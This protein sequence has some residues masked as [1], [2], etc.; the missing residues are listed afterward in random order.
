MGRGG[1]DIIKDRREMCP[2]Q[3]ECIIA[4]M[5][6]CYKTKNWTADLADYA[7]GADYAYG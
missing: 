2:R 5:F 4:Q 7:G 3:S 6:W 1:V